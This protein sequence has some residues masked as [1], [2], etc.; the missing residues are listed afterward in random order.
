MNY[1]VS[2]RVCV[3]VSLYYYS[4]AKYTEDKDNVSH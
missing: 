1:C 3:C 4:I 2:K